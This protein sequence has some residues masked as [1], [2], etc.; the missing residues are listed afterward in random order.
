[1]KKQNKQP[2]RLPASRAHIWAHCGG[3]VTL[4]NTGNPFAPFDSARKGILTHKIAA[5]HLVHGQESLVDLNAWEKQ[6]YEANRE[7]ID[8]S[9]QFYVSFIFEAWAEF[10]ES[11]K[12][13]EM[14]VERNLKIE[15]SGYVWEGPPD[16]YFVSTA[17]QVVRV[18]D[19]KSGWVE[20]EAEGNEQ[21]TLYG[22]SIAFLHN[23][24]NPTLTGTIVQPLLKQYANATYAFDPSFFDTLRVDLKSF[25]V[26]SHCAKCPALTN[27]KKA[28]EKIEFFNDPKF[29]D[30]TAARAKYWPELLEIA[31]PAIEFF[32]RVKTEGKAYI[33]L[34]GSIAGWGLAKTNLG[35]KRQWDETV[36]AAKLQ[37][38]L[39]L[40]E[41]DVTETKLLGP[42]GVEKVLKKS[43]NKAGLE[44][45]STLCYMPSG[46]KLARVEEKE[47]FMKAKV[48]EAKGSKLTAGKTAK[49]QTTK[50]GK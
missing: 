37:K 44:K 2:I 36:T 13:A 9:V 39:K 50:K 38:E 16:V 45:L 47:A 28:K 29:L 31:E 30:S 34:G 48:K 5:S 19:L 46:V 40:K 33:E 49:K 4:K 32:K 14:H 43:G 10:R 6:L 17:R 15:K 25:S 7:E 3:S 21:L 12:T 22:H 42:A 1:M 27:C 18:F 24:K 23:L 8:E 41:T 20:V 26:G 35:Q 11:D